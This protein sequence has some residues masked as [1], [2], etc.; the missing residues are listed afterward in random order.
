VPNPAAPVLIE[1]SSGNDQLTGTILIDLI[2]G[3]A[4]DDVLDGGTGN[5]HLIGGQGDDTYVTD[6][7]DIIFEAAGEGT[8]TVQ[9]TGAFFLSDN[10]ENLT[11]T[12]AD[13]Q[14]T[15]FG[16]MGNA[17]ANVMRGFGASFGFH[18][19]AGNDQLF[20]ADGDDLLDGG[21]GIDVL[22]GGDGSDIYWVGNAGEHTTAEF[23]DSG[24][25][26]VDEIRFAAYEAGTL[27]LFAGDTGIERV[28]LLDTAALSVN[29]SA[30][31]NGLF[32]YGNS[33]ANT[34]VGSAFAD[35]LDGGDGSDILTGGLGADVLSSHTGLDTFRDS[36]AGLNG[37]SIDF[38]R[39]DT[40]LFTDAT[41][42][43]FDFT[44]SNGV[45]TYSGG[46]LTI[47]G[48]FTGNLTAA[49][50][51]GG[52]VALTST[53]DARN[54][55]NG[56]GRSDILWRNV[57]TIGNWLA[58][59]TGTHA[60]NP[61]SIASVSGYWDL[62]GVGDFNGDGRDDVLWRGAGG[63]L[64]NW[65]ANADG[66]LTY[67]AA[68]GVTVIP[69]SWQVESVGDF[70][71][72]NRDDILWRNSDGSV[73]VWTAT[74]IGGFFPNNAMVFHVSTDWHIVAT[75]DFNGDGKDD[76][77]WRHDNGAFADWLAGYSS[78]FTPNFASLVG[79]TNDWH[80][81]GVGDFNG[82]N[83]EDILW[84]HDS[85]TVANWTANAD[86]TFSPN[87][88]SLVSITNDWNAASIGDYNG[89]GRDDI[90]WRHDSGT[91]A[92][93]LANSDDSGTF[94]TNQA[95]FAAVANEWQVQDPPVLFL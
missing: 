43:G 62:A 31:L 35:R 68:I 39:G 42:D 91:I 38:Q 40:I 92:S 88:A 80:I 61:P 83:R 67:N 12:I 1:G 94:T 49:A 2:T 25:G 36:R 69:N 18:G 5:D 33:F 66:S 28:A 7:G 72:D 73:G 56:D 29:A 87:F 76:I 50:A 45:L 21:A 52:G 15:N 93:W 60:F 95:S 70:N 54:D 11:I 24:S 85:G 65:L 13:A 55:F 32:I 53:A 81:V 47:Q 34:L 57:G 6:G 63:E 37:D 10:L 4:G 20:G 14:N 71:G 3:L 19:L 90:L 8:D 58:E 51:E 17:A 89:D 82:D 23:N 26:D 86:G 46:S 64:G 16:G 77:L 22:D 79:I 75:G 48:G 30:V 44:F 74:T 9:A 84:R 27:T 78:G 59:A 41:L